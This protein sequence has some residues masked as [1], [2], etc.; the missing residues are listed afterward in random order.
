MARPE[1]YLAFP[2]DS[3][4]TIGSAS[5]DY[6]RLMKDHHQRKRSWIWILRA[7]GALEYCF[8]TDDTKM[9]QTGVPAWIAFTKH[10]PNLEPEIARIEINIQR[11]LLV[12]NGTDLIAT[13]NGVVRHS[14]A[15]LPEGK[16][17]ACLM[18]HDRVKFCRGHVFTHLH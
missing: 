4:D 15:I 6:H 17:G 1:D 10:R 12:E 8:I 18:A 14:V 9:F 5:S 11:N 2:G 3:G 13:E 7:C 16:V